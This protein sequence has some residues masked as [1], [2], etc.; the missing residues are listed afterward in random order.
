MAT[1]PLLKQRDMYTNGLCEQTGFEKL[2]IHKTLQTCFEHILKRNLLKINL[3]INSY[4]NKKA[5]R[6][7]EV[8]IIRHASSLFL[9]HQQ[10]TFRNL[11]CQRE[12]Y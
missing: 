12:C 11:F 10:K 6:E 1:Y 8:L 7:R 9:M 5:E 3:L 4:T 2:R